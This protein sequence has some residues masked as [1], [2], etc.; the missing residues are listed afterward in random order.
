MQITQQMTKITK[1]G[2]KE[3]SR[4]RKLMPTKRTSG[5]ESETRLVPKW[6]NLRAEIKIS[7]EV[8][9]VSEIEICL[10]KVASSEKIGVD[11]FRTNL[12]KNLSKRVVKEEE[13]PKKEAIR[14]AQG[15]VVKAEKAKLEV[16]AEIS[17]SCLEM[18]HFGTKIYVI[19]IQIS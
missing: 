2:R 1:L 3:F 9:A 5:E 6:P 19:S 8:G 14:R 13:I 12:G 16:N 18:L 15:R 10:V 7:D 4:T 11:S 17:D